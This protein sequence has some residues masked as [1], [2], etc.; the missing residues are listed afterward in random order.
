MPI[1]AVFG[2]SIPVVGIKPNDEEKVTG[3]ALVDA[4]LAHGVEHF[5][6]TSVDRHGADSDSTD[7]DIPHF[8]HKAHVEKHLIEVCKN[9]KMTWTILRPTVFMDNIVLGFAGK[10]YPTAWKVGLSPDKKLQLIATKDIGYFG[11]QA[12][13]SPKWFAG[14]AISLAGDELTFAEANTIF[15]REIG[16]DIPTTFG[17]LASALIWAVKDVH[18]MFKFFEN[19]GYAADVQTLRVEHPGL[20]SFGDWVKT[21]DFAAK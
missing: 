17:A 11:A 16:C 20:L 15:A 18:L 19:V 21:C 14:R 10:M 2:V 4:A 7:T 8:V 12:L 5:V 9:S 6:Y 3:K 13:L 1:K